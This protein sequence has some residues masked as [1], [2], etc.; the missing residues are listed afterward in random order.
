LSPEAP[1]SRCGKVA[2]FH[3][4][5]LAQNE[6]LCME[7]AFDRQEVIFLAEVMQGKHKALIAE[8]ERRL[9]EER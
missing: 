5:E 4:E 7:C 8:L 3:E 1:C 9:Q 6:A 2:L